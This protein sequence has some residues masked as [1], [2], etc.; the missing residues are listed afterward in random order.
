MSKQN[1]QLK[2]VIDPVYGMGYRFRTKTRQQA[3]SEII[4]QLES[5]PD[6]ASFEV[7]TWEEVKGM[8]GI[9]KG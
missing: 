7:T 2:K 9:V 1:K 5:H 8:T 6:V 3:L 4:K